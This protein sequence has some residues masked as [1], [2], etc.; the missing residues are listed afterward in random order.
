MQVLT[1]GRPDR[2]RRLGIELPAALA[3]HHQIA[4]SGL[5][6]P[7]DALLGGDAPIHHHQGVAGGLERLQHLRQGPMLGHVAGEDLGAA[8]ETAA[9]EHE[10]QGEEGTIP[11]LVLGMPPL[12][13]GLILGPAL[14]VT[15]GEIVEGDRGPQIE[16]AH[17]LLEQV[18][19]NGVPVRHQG[20]RGPVQLHRAHGLEVDPQ[21]FA[22]AAAFTQ[23]SV[24][25]PFR[26]GRGQTP[27]NRSRRGGAQGAIDAQTLEQFPQPQPVHRPQTGLLHAHRT[28]ARQFQRIHLHGHGPRLGRGV[29]SGAGEV[30]FAGD[31]LG[32]D[33]LGFLLQGGRIVR[34]EGVLSGKQFLD[35]D[36]QPGPVRLRDVKVP[37]QVEQGA[38]ADL[39]ADAFGADEA[40]GEVDL[41][42]FGAA[43]L[44]AANE[45]GN[46]ITGGASEFNPNITIMALHS[47]SQP[48]INNLRAGFGQIWRNSHPI[49]PQMGKHGLRFP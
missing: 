24:R 35:P 21:Q 45:H 7:G 33:A 16:Q 18:G 47:S 43:G 27:D 15:V 1:R 4:V 17:R 40:V 38:L 37:S 32:R 5:A 23:P 19:F 26:C 39:G 29:G 46:T 13:L 25:R 28:R 12:R 22:Q 8:D 10:P 9:I 48:G 49:K 30:G 3:A 20:V 11:A 41:A 42:V 36:A 44:G 6:Q 34:D 14:E 31:Q 2:D